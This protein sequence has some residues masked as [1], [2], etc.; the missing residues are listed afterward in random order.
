MKT[1]KI[2]SMLVCLM[3]FSAG[4]TSCSDDDEDVNPSLLVG[5]WEIVSNEGY[6]Y[7]PDGQRYDY[8]EPG[9]G[10]TVEF[11][12]DGTVNFDGDTGRWSVSG[13]RLTLSVYGESASAEITKL[14]NTELVF[15]ASGRDEDGDWFDRFV[16]RRVD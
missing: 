8:N 2:W 12:E 1:W 5:K 7:D 10:E 6:Y 4:L 13:N 16:L 15:E 11:F 3:A 14:T 9:Y